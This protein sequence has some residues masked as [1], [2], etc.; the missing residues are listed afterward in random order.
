MSASAL[1]WDLA[2]TGGFLAYGLL[3]LSIALGLALSLHWYS[4][5]WPRWATTD[6]HRYVTLLTLVFIG[7][8]TIA[9]WLDPFMTFRLI[10]IVVPFTS[11][12]RPIW[13]ALGIIGAY[14]ALAIWLSERIQ[15]RIGYAWWRRL[16]YATFAAYALTTIHGLADGTDTRT[17]WGVVIYGGSMLL[18][19]SLLAVR[20]LAPH[21]QSRPHRR[22][23]LGA[24]GAV[25]SVVLWALLGPLRAG[26]STSALAL[27][28]GPPA[29]A[30]SSVLQLP[31]SAQIVGHMSQSGGADSTGL[32]TVRIAANL[33]GGQ[34]SLQMT[35]A[36]PTQADGSLAIE[37]SRVVFTTQRSGACVGQVNAVEQGTFG[38]S[39]AGPSGLL[40]NLAITVNVD[41]A[42]NVTGSIRATAG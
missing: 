11:H 19:G 12:Y 24:G 18:V 2:R 28:G 36:G 16:H 41:G 27:S 3:T 6:L 7:V 13:T 8:H 31:L 20:L 33:S 42:G 10:E 22:V 29:V 23:A 5:S 30:R 40:L 39:C 35:L 34:G 14:L 1:T 38:A 17:V 4:R 25:V 37:S 32:T 21:A 26:W 15:R 9:V